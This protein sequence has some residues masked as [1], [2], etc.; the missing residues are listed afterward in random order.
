MHYHHVEASFEDRSVNTQHGIWLFR[1]LQA[2]LHSIILNIPGTR[3]FGTQ[4][5]LFATSQQRPLWADL[6]QATE[7]ISDA[8]HRNQL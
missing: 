7:I 5:L 2:G 8:R 4:F 1:T 3:K 6:E